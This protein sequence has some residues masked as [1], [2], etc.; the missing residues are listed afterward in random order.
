MVNSAV[1][2]HGLTQALCHGLHS[3]SA[4]TGKEIDSLLGYSSELTSAASAAAVIPE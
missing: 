2:H 1:L 4:L 3:G